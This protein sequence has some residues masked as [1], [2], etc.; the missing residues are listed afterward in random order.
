MRI[1][2]A[3]TVTQYVIE[4]L[5]ALGLEHAFG[6][7]GDY[8]FP[9][10]DAI[11]SNPD[12]QWIGSANELNAAY[13]AD[14]YARIRGAGVLC[15]TFGPGE[16]SAIC[17]VMGARAESVPI[18]WLV[19]M[20]STRLQRDRRIPHHMLRDGDYYRNARASWIATVAHTELTPDNAVIETERMIATAFRHREPVYLL[21]AHDLAKLPV[22]I[23]QGVEAST[24]P[25][26]HSRSDPTQ[27]RR[28]AAAIQDRLASAETAVALP[29]YRIARFGLESKLLD[30][31]E[32]AGIPFAQQPMDK[33]TLSERHPQYLGL[34]FGI[35]S[36][37]GVREAVENADVILDFEV[38]DSDENTA[39]WT[40]NLDAGRTIT[41]GAEHVRV[42]ERIFAPVALTDILDL[43]AAPK[44]PFA[45]PTIP[46]T[47]PP[48]AGG[49]D[50]S[51]S[52]ALIYPRLQAFLGDNDIV[53]SETGMSNSPMHRLRMPEG[54]TFLNQ[55]LW[56]SIGWATPAAFGACLAAPERRVL[57]V[58]GDGAHQLTAN[59]LGAM[60]RYGA[61]PI[62]V[63][64]NNGV[65]GI[66]EV[67]SDTEELGHEYNNLAAWRYSEVPRALGCDGWFTTQVRT[68]GEF[69]EALST[70]AG[71]DSGSLIE[72]MLDRSDLPPRMPGEI[73]ERLYGVPRDL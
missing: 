50:D 32:G 35:A 34:Y 37:P 11:E 10:N 70:A 39:A 8:S 52:S 57:V 29:S 69:S 23:E 31:I 64:L 36:D 61:R 60:G 45:R 51:L 72:V 19:G 44:R 28:A 49:D 1:L 43:I 66:E 53:V 58:T 12:M 71:H 33:A 48:D 27:L 67:L 22:V 68:A 73:L 38:L 46:D 24:F 6:V 20:P 3:P 65:F 5:A 42:G 17:G 15:T 9:W 59:E 18:F 55:P 41:F 25:L 47:P 40:G 26:P 13:A 2:S 7:P 62:V 14:G 4:R 54:A 30:F 16:L 21:V 56:G 63:L